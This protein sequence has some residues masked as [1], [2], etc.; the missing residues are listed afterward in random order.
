MPPIGGQSRPAAHRSRCAA[1]I[2][3]LHVGVACGKAHNV[4]VKF[5]WRRRL[6]G[7][8]SSGYDAFISYSHA[9]DGRLAPIFQQELENFAKPWYRLRSLRVFRDD[10]SLTANPGLWSSIEGALAGSAWFVL[11]ASPEAAKSPWV[12]R[13]VSWW[14]AHRSAQRLLI[15]LTG[16]ELLWDG[17]A[18]DFDWAATSALP[19]ALGGAFAEEPRWTDLGRLRDAGHVD[20]S[21][22]RLRDCVADV[23][24]AVRGM[25]KDLLVGEHIRQHRRALRLARGGVTALAGLLDGHGRGC[26]AGCRAA[27]HGGD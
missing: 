17:S 4:C 27:E 20:G 11:M 24:A 3:R 23:A 19:P 5:S 13:E 15:V 7:R 14:L 1:A 16:G 26:R 22:P 21:N 10:A 18:G 9:L 6:P 2:I 12:D 25:P 8:S